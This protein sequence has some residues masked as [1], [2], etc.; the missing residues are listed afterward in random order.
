[1]CYRSSRLHSVLSIE[2]RPRLRVIACTS[3]LIVWHG[4]VWAGLR[5]MEISWSFICRR[6]TC[7]GCRF[8]R[9]QSLG[10]QKIW[11]GWPWWETAGEAT[12]SF[13]SMLDVR[14]CDSTVT[15]E[16]ALNLNTNKASAAVEWTICTLQKRY[17]GKI[18]M[19]GRLLFFE[20][21]QHYENLLK[22]SSWFEKKH[23]K[24][25]N[26]YVD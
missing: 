14:K 17:S 23:T 7:S 16:Y 10:S 21:V 15:V 2:H 20:Y 5:G 19:V 25:W 13:R 12:E 24:I 26:S 11:I 4:A 1:M 6:G 22:W 18:A 9:L 8:T 3:C